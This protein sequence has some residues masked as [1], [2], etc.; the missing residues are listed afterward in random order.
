MFD[1]DLQKL[2]TQVTVKLLDDKGQP[3][4]NAKPV[5]ADYSVTNSSLTETPS[6][7]LI[8][9]DCSLSDANGEARCEIQTVEPGI[10]KI[11][12]AKVE[13]QDRY[14]NLFMAEE[15][16]L[17]EVI[18]YP[19]P[20]MFGILIGT[21]STVHTGGGTKIQ[22]SGDH[23]RSGASIYI[24]GLP[25]ESVEVVSANLASCVSPAL[26]AGIKSLKIVNDDKQSAEMAD[27]ITAS[28]TARVIS[29]S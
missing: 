7:K 12:I 28:A 19:K 20:E 23:F 9:S 17:K 8:F 5:L 2:V 16:R 3:L 27:A 15:S 13:S 6:S 26:S 14:D 4:P 29:M 25:C 21:T 1:A 11:Y 10:Y 18:F 24:D 22:I